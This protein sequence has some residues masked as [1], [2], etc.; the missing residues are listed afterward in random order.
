M[1]FLENFLHS[2]LYISSS[3]LYIKRIDEIFWQFVWAF[4]PTDLLHFFLNERYLCIDDAS[5]IETHSTFPQI[6]LNATKVC[7]NVFLTGDIL[8]GISY[9]NVYLL[10]SP[11]LIGVWHL[12]WSKN[13]QWIKIFHLSYGSLKSVKLKKN[14]VRTFDWIFGIFMNFLEKFSQFKPLYLQF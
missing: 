4:Y 13:T 11:V 9:S 7:L 8:H 14:Y 1:N 6:K 2:N 5:T 3:N 10:I 12:F